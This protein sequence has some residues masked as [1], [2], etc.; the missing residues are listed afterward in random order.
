MQ[1]GRKSEKMDQEIE[2]L[3]TRL[4]DLIAVDGASQHDTVPPASCARKVARQ[5]LPKYLLREDHIIA[6]PE[7]ACSECGGKLSRRARRRPGSW[8]SSTRLSS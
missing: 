1:F 8:K 7:Q 4:D 6:P 2:K 5:P 3:E